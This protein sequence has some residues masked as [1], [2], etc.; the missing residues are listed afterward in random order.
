[1]PA[2]PPP[3]HGGHRAAYAAVAVVT[4]AVV[5]IG[6]QQVHLSL[7]AVHL[8]TI[9]LLT[10]GVAAAGVALRPTA[11]ARPADELQR[12]A[13]VGSSVGAYLVAWG[14]AVLM[15]D[16]VFWDDWTLVE[17]PTEAMLDGFQ[18]N[19]L[20]WVGFLHLA[21]LELGPWAYRLVGALAF[22]GVGLAVFAIVR[23]LPTFHG[24]PAVTAR[25]AWLLAT[26]VLVL[27]FNSARHALITLPYTLS[28][29]L[30]TSAWWLLVRRTPAPPAA[31]VAA[32]VLLFVSFTT[33]SLL[34]FVA[35][36]VGHLLLLE[37]GDDR[38]PGRIVRWAARRWYLLAAP[39]VFYA[40]KATWFAPYGLYEGY[41]QLVVSRLATA[42]LRVLL[43]AL[44]L[45]VV[46][47]R[48][49]R[50]PRALTAA[51][52]WIVAGLLLVSIGELPY[53]AAGH[54]PGFAAW[55]SRHQ[56][57]VPFGWATVGVGLVRLATAVLGDVP[58]R[59]LAVAGVAVAALTSLA[60]TLSFVVDHRKQGE[61]V[62]LLRAQPE[63]GEVPSVV[64]RDHT[65]GLNANQRRWAYYEYNGLFAAA[66]GNTS[67]FVIPEGSYVL[68]LRRG[69]MDGVRTPRYQAGGSHPSDEAIHVRIVQ[70]GSGPRPLWPYADLRL[71]LTVERTRL[72]DYDETGNRPAP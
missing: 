58:G 44:A 49:Q 46:V 1:M 32:T 68:R 16:A 56:L 35:L 47:R 39:V 30:F 70:H 55:N 61:L 22:L 18:Q 34:V 45:A 41:N 4:L 51:T 71:A 57:L 10:V 54:R 31:V 33:Q 8:P 11:S 48:H 28:L 2:Q 37:L 72:S 40:A 14:G 60:L 64:V 50:S 52:V 27:P 12:Q 38:R 62:A 42:T 5:A 65:R 19:G 24:L 21:A 25:D 7:A 63:I 6:W 29:A 66:Y 3:V 36:P 26:L 13:A 59:R 67:R 23:R 17:V 9:L 20:P 43:L 69:E 53:L 15:L